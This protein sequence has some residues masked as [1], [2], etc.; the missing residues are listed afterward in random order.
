MLATLAPGTIGVMTVALVVELEPNIVIPVSQSL[1]CFRI[2]WRLNAIESVAM[3]E[4]FVAKIK[5]AEEHMRFIA[6]GIR[7][8]FCFKEFYC[9]YCC[10][11]LRLR[12]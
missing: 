7:S 5:S 9:P 10:L 1:E 3:A 2:V 4:K 11:Q 12:K 6:I 8:E